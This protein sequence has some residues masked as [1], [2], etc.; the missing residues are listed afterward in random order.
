MVREIKHLEEGS[1]AHLLLVEALPA[2]YEWQDAGFLMEP[3]MVFYE[4]TIRLVK[5]IN[6]FKKAR[7]EYNLKKSKEHLIS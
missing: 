2:F 1:T 3:D 4:K 7:E 6:D 5:I